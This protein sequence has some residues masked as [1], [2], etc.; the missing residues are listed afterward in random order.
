[1]PRLLG[2]KALRGLVLAVLAEEPSEQLCVERPQR[3]GVR[4]AHR[5]VNTVVHGDAVVANDRPKDRQRLAKGFHRHG[6]WVG[7]FAAEQETEGEVV[8]RLRG[9]SGAVGA[10]RGDFHLEGALELRER[11]HSLPNALAE[12]GGPERRGVMR[13]K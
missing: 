3:K 4:L 7:I 9:R 1:M 12:I 8:L 10:V 11:N 6:P 13:D 2:I 5:L